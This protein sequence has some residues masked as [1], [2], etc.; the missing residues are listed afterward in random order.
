MRSQEP[1]HREASPAA[2]AAGA[3]T[4]IELLVVI[5]II[6]ILAAMLLPALGQA[7]EAGRRIQCTS[8]LRQIDLSLKLYMDDN[9]DIMPTRRSSNNRWPALL[10][11]YYQVLTLLRCPSDGPDPVS[12]AGAGAAPA[13]RAPRSYIINGW[14]DYF[15]GTNPTN[16][17][18]DTAIPEPS[19]TITFGE[20]ET[21]SGHFW[22]DFMEGTGN[23]ITELEQ[24]RHGTAGRNNSSGG[25]SVHA[26]AD[27]SVRYLRYGKALVPVNMWAITP[28]WRT[29][30]ILLQ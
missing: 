17:L 28:Y 22:M 5:A 30:G 4:L 8:D 26:F 9:E 11:P 29:N 15:G 1:F 27:G 14:N 13:D 23:D 25:G 24:S 2:A 3:F 7:K 12:N 10:Y 6:A 21:K 18:K 20:K 19:E 16:D